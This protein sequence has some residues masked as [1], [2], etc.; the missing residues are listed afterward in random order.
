[1]VA[2]FDARAEGRIVMVRQFLTPESA[3]AGW[4]GRGPLGLEEPADMLLGQLQERGDLAG[5]LYRLGRER[6]LDEQDEASMTPKNGSSD[7]PRIGF[8]TSRRPAGG[9]ILSNG[10]R[11]ARF[12][13]G[14]SAKGAK[15]TWPSGEF[16]PG[17]LEE[18]AHSS[19][20]PDG[21]AILVPRL[22]FRYSGVEGNPGE[23]LRLRGTG[24]LVGDSRAI[25]RK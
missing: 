14:R 4:V 19:D 12:G 22:D 13:V 7:E 5:R 9:P 23:T 21:P 1:M 20:I 6:L 25:T 10:R 3:I 15:R 16:G 11:S 2:P 24:R 17:S 8:T 18:R